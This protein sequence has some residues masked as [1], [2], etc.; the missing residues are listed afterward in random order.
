[1]KKRLLAWGLAVCIVLSLFPMM[2]L[3]ETSA[4]K[5]VINENR[6]I[7]VDGVSYRLVLGERIIGNG[8]TKYSGERYVEFIDDPEDKISFESDILLLD[9][10]F[11]NEAPES[12]YQAFWASCDITIDKNELSNV[13]V[14]EIQT[15]EDGYHKFIS[16]SII[17]ETSGSLFVR[18]T[19]DNNENAM[20]WRR[21]VSACKAT[22][23][24][25]D[26]DGQ[27]SFEITEAQANAVYAFYI[28]LGANKTAE[29]SARLTN[30]N[31]YGK[32]T[33][34]NGKFLWTHFEKDNKITEYSNSISAQKIMFLVY[35]FAFTDETTTDITGTVNI[36]VEQPKLMYRYMSYDKSTSIWY[37]DPNA[38]LQ[39]ISSLSVDANGNA[40]V[41]FYYGTSADYQPITDEKLVSNNESVITTSTEKAN[42]GNDFY[43]IFGHDFGTATLTY[44][45]YQF[46]VTVGLPPY[47]FYSAQS[48]DEAHFLSV[49]NTEDLTDNTLWFMS[50]NGFTEEDTKSGTYTVVASDETEIPFTWVKRADIPEYDMKISMS[51]SVSL[52][53]IKRDGGNWQS[54]RV[55]SPGLMYRYMSYNR[56]TQSW[57][58]NTN[59]SAQAISGLN[60][61]KGEEAKIRL[62]YGTSSEHQLLTGLVSGN[63][64]VVSV[65]EGTA[66]DGK[67]YYII[68]SSDF[69][70][71][72]LTCGEHQFELTVGLPTYGF[73]SSSQ[74]SAESYLNK[75]ALTGTETDLTEVWFVG[76]NAFV[77]D[78]IT[79]MA[80]DTDITETKVNKVDDRTLKI[81]LPSGMTSSYEL[82]VMLGASKLRGITVRLP[83]SGGNQPDGEVWQGDYAA[84]IDNYVI[85]FA[86]K[87][88][89]GKITKICENADK[90][91][92]HGTIENTSPDV[93]Y[94]KEV[95][96]YI[97]AATKS[98]DT[99]DTVIYTV[100][101]DVMDNLVINR[102]WLETHSGDNTTY[103]WSD[104]RLVT[105]LTSVG[106]DQ[107][108]P[109]YVKEGRN[110]EATICAQIAVMIGGQ[111]YEKTVRMNIGLTVI[112]FSGLNRPDNDTVEQLN[113][114][115]EELAAQ[116]NTTDSKNE[117]YHIKLGNTTYKGT[118]HVPAAFVRGHGC[119]HFVGASQNG[120]KTVVKGSLN[121]NGAF[122][123]YINDIHFVCDESSAA[124][125]RAIFGGGLGRI[126]NCSFYGYDI[127][128]DSS[129]G[130][131]NASK[132][133][134]VNNEIAAAIKINN[135]MD[136]ANTLPHDWNNNT[137]INNGIA[138]QILSL[139]KQVSPYYFRIYDSNFINNGTDIDAR[140]GGTLYMY[141]NYF[142]QYKEVDGR[143][144]HPGKHHHDRYNGREHLR[145]DELLNARTETKLN[146]ILEYRTAKIR[147]DNN[148]KVITN[149]RWRH[150]VKGWWSH[151]V[152][153]G[154]TF[155]GPKQTTDAL[156]ALDAETEY[157][158][159]MI[160]DWENETVILNEESSDLVLDASAF[161][162]A[163]E[164]EIGVLD[165]KEAV[166][167]TWI[168]K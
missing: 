78:T 97:A 121:I 42:D 85:G 27:A 125:T 81:T 1:M 140:C 162:S 149:P 11:Q 21:T 4:P 10:N 9:E 70:T 150:P 146:G 69:G 31:V 152:L 131:I 113:A 160:A 61:A 3:A 133:V 2:A 165:D 66:E 40:K 7:T 32:V 92:G 45:D 88:A 15:R 39:D 155:F 56:D 159:T 22:E 120:K 43:Y 34:E 47:G 154:D 89:D 50:E 29:V 132:S 79:V 109:L 107:P 135:S 84:Y 130:L 148:T 134:F 144:P 142:G 127:A 153:V 167:G 19:Q 67:G 138:V 8:I 123:E 64:S 59:K 72:T 30:E 58:E 48:R 82:S 46:E 99:T 20:L 38:S 112:D 26:N 51:S 54:I 145:L 102:L 147:T 25:L 105:E 35:P 124:E 116:I 128:L 63:P 96:I 23:L 75:I 156:M 68:T 52:V 117:I 17:G 76:K 18:A 122:I 103:S 100:D 126:E 77:D 65:S 5:I 71:V 74:P 57:Y 37:E 157:K 137:F 14:S 80:G 16:C 101:Q 83:S 24:H 168:F 44:G 115:L 151:N 62:Y 28:D 166:L 86:E 55:Y 111:A 53:I 94:H 73:Y 158:D 36:E 90:I 114:F 108:V 33:L 106:K 136:S 163:G 87:R 119:L 13:T 95:D 93:R 143:R 129:E 6:E 12:V 164:K 49:A 141:R 104:D 60:L 41:R 139:N 98:T 110:C 118:I 161:T 91:Y